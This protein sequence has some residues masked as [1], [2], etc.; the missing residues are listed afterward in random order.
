MTENRLIWRVTWT[1][2]NADTI[3]MAV[4]EGLGISVISG[5]AVENEIA[6]GQLVTT[7]LD[8]IRFD[9]KFKIVYHKNKYLTEQ[10]KKFI[11]LCIRQE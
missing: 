11:D 10:M 9:R 1:C 8:G 3:K 6:S 5:R 7:T 2:N 4:A